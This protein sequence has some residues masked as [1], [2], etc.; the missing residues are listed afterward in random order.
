[1]GIFKLP[2]LSLVK[3]VRYSLLKACCPGLSSNR[4]AGAGSL[5]LAA[6]DQFPGIQ[7]ALGLDIN[8][9]YIDHLEALVSQSPHQHKTRVLCA[10][11]FE[12]RWPQLLRHYPDSLL[13]L[14]NP[15][16]VTSATLGSIGSSNLPAKSNF[17]NHRG[18]DAITGK[19]NFD[20][21][22]WMMLRIFDWLNGRDATLAFLCK[23]I[24]AR[25]LLKHAWKNEF[26]LANSKLYEIDTSTHFGAAVDACLLVCTFSPNRNSFDCALYSDFTATTPASTIGY[27]NHKLIADLRL[28]DRWKHLEGAELYKWRSG[29]K[30]DCSPVLD[31]SQEQQHY[32]NGLGERVEIEDTY[33]FPMLKSSDLAKRNVINPARRMLVTQHYIGEKTDDIRRTAPNTWRYLQQHASFLDRRASSIYKNRPAF[34]IFGVGDYSFSPWKVAISGFYKQIAFIAV[35]PSANKP[36]VL[37]DTCYFIPCRTG[38]EAQFIAALLNSG[39]AQ[40]FY[41][42]FVFWDSKRPITVDLLRRLDVS[43]LA[44]ELGSERV[45]SRL[46]ADRIVSPQPV[47]FQI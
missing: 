22:E 38:E 31:L 45:L 10:D 19:A 26:H 17:Q 8:H 32:V 15:P 1:L 21:S 33:L 13:V 24:V 16:W 36:V 3:S 37:D 14:G 28:Y 40:E 34:S 44:R 12:T 6:L 39:P 46:L 7:N 20:I 47:L 43:A 35:G 25:K 30:H 27:R 5:L 29:I 41:R 11:F 9:N 2:A 4:P 23:T 42:A 18:M